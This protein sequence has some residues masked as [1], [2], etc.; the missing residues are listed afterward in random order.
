MI[1]DPYLSRPLRF[2]MYY[3]R[4][5]QM[6]LLVGVATINMNMAAA[7]Y[8]PLLTVIPAFL[9]FSVFT[10]M[11]N[12]VVARILYFMTSITIIVGCW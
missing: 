10:G 4:I 8:I 5:V 9:V 1:F 12:R 2:A 3:N 7:I 11:W 6:I